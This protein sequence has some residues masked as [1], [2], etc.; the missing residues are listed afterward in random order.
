[1]IWIAPTPSTVT[2]HPAPLVSSHC[3]IAGTNPP[4]AGVGYDFAT[5]IGS[6]TLDEV[7]A[8]TEANFKVAPDLKTKAA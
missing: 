2:G 7:K 6:V 1:M 5:G 4:I 8:K 3:Q